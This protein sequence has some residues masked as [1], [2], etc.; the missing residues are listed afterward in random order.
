[1]FGVWRC[2]QIMLWFSLLLSFTLNV[3]VPT[4]FVVAAR[5]HTFLETKSRKEVD[6][7]GQSSDR[8]EMCI[9]FPR[10]AI[11]KARQAWVGQNL[12]ESFILKIPAESSMV[13]YAVRGGNLY[14]G[15]RHLRSED[16]NSSRDHRLIEALLWSTLR[17]F[18]DVPDADL[19]IAYG[20]TVSNSHVRKLHAPAFGFSARRAKNA[21]WDN[22]IGFPNPYFVYQQMLLAQR[23]GH[24]ENVSWGGKQ[25]T[26]FWRGALTTHEKL[27]SAEDASKQSRVRL[28][29]IAAHHAGDW[30]VSYTGLDHLDS[31]SDEAEAMLTQF[32]STRLQSTGPEID[33]FVE[34]PRYKYLLNVEGV[35]ASWRGL[36]LLASGSVVLQQKSGT[37]EFFDGDLAP[38]VHYVPIR[39]D[40]A[41]LEHAVKFLRAHDKV[42]SFLGRQAQDFANSN[43]TLSA[44]TCYCR[45]VLRFMAELASDVLLPR[46]ELI[47]KHGF[48]L[49]P[50]DRIVSN[51]ILHH[52]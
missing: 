4:E 9:D 40:L 23:G 13:A 31:W 35:A 52:L 46:E 5:G 3:A 7:R 19:V 34:L 33:F 6:A 41:N 25:N 1:M 10:S 20:D 11:S 29:R 48:L 16:M 38:W 22:L 27:T 39:H 2:R 51:F 21:R 42:A 24:A 45:D 47:D 49:V 15:S 37:V 12:Q 32:Y 30:N 43:L 28:G 18:S 50:E 8:G 17:R 44:S 14:R 26:V 36:Q